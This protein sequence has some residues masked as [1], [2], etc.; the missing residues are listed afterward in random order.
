MRR[1]PDLPIEPNDEVL[2]VLHRGG[3]SHRCS[4]SPTPMARGSSSRR[5]WQD[6]TGTGAL[7]VVARAAPR[8]APTPVAGELRRRRCATS[9]SR[10]SAGS[11]L[12]QRRPIGGRRAHELRS[13]PDEP[14]DQWSAPQLGTH[15]G[16]GRPRG[17][18]AGAPSPN[19]KRERGYG[20][21][22]QHPRAGD[23]RP[24]GR[25]MTPAVQRSRNVAA[26]NPGRGRAG[27]RGAALREHHP[28]GLR[29]SAIRPRG[30]RA[31]ARGAASA[32]RGG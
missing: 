3:S 32:R 30:F 29:A 13:A 19:A 12:A 8:S 27:P 15:P 14:G 9:G 22:A 11:V 31:A 24:P 28:R 10:R 18:G 17:T 16:W 2:E 4:S 26:H 21:G 6:R 5:R 20:Q 25:R 1:T 23:A 7:R